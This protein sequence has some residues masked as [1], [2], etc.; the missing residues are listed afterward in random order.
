M[1]TSGNT[2]SLKLSNFQ[3][4]LNPKKKIKS[5][6][7]KPKGADLQKDKQDSS[8]L[9]SNHTVIAKHPDAKEEPGEQLLS[10]NPIF[11]I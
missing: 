4:F 10:W 5:F 7:L 8:A 3:S 1:V 6:K 11:S 9:A 2:I